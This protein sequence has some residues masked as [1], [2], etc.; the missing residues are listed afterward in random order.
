M[1]T[2]PHPHLE[3]VNLRAPWLYEIDD[4]ISLIGA[5]PHPNH[6]G[7][8]SGGTQGLS[9]LNLQL[10]VPSHAKLT[11]TAPRTLT[12]TLTPHPHQVP[13]HAELQQRFSEL[14]LAP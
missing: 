13:N 14:T 9:L 2:R 3:P 5:T 12:L 10:N 1:R 11:L 6:T 4:L 7:G 8:D